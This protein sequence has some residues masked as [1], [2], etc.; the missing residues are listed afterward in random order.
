MSDWQTGDLC[1]WRR[2]TG[3]RWKGSHVLGVMRDKGGSVKVLNKRTGFPAFVRNDP[4]YIK[5]RK[6]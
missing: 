4:A 1:Y 3:E 2:H 5:E 6:R